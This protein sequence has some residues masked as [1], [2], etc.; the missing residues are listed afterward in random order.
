MYKKGHV[1]NAITDDIFLQ[2]E[3]EGTKLVFSTSEYYNFKI[4][5]LGF[6]FDA[7]Y[8]FVKLILN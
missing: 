5:K 1:L 2:E 4:F 8:F 7:L 6:I 3:A